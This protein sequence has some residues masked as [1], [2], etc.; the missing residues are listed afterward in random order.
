MSAAWGGCTEIY[1]MV[2][3][4][5]TSACNPILCQRLRIG[6]RN[7]WLCY[8][9]VGVFALPS[10][11]PHTHTHTHTHKLT[12]SSS[13][14]H[15]HA[16]K[17]TYMH[18]SNTH[19]Y[20]SLSTYIS[21]WYSRTGWLGIKHQV[22]YSLLYT[23]ASKHTHLQR[24]RR[25]M[26]QSV[27]LRSTKFIT[28]LDSFPSAPAFFFVW[29]SSIKF[30][31]IQALVEQ[32]SDKTTKHQQ[33]YMYRSLWYICNVCP[34]IQIF[35][36]NKEVFLQVESQTLLWPLRPCMKSYRWLLPVWL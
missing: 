11:L 7:V 13:H 25:G 1:G 18:T 14:P 23:H 17:Q 22:T 4:Q 29:H 16:S 2:I 24:T 6:T 21:P 19:N 15:P 27:H 32:S 9:F 31:T 8:C 10:S 28:M 35:I 12:Y 20:M 26:I 33:A 36:M 5:T 30:H 34:L 3:I